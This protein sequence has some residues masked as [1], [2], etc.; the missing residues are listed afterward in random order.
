MTTGSVDRRDLQEKQINAKLQIT[1]C[2][3]PRLFVLL[4]L[5]LAIINH[6]TEQ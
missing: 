1:P 5:D 4:Q 3:K 6:Q 2:K